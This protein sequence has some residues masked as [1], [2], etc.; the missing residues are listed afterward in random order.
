MCMRQLLAVALVL[1][2][3]AVSAGAQRGGGHGGGSAGFHGG[4]FSG[5][6]AV[7]SHG[8]YSGAGQARYAS[9]SRVQSYRTVGRGFAPGAGASAGH[10]MGSGVSS[11]RPA[12][13]NRGRDGRREGFRRGFP[14]VYPGLL[15]DGWV[16]PDYLDDGYPDDGGYY[17]DD[18]GDGSAGDPGVADN[19]VEQPPEQYEQPGQQYE[20]PGPEETPQNLYVAPRRPVAPALYEPDAVTLVFKD[21]RPSQQI[22]NYALTRTTLYV[23]DAHHRD[24]PVAD[25][26]LAA[27]EKVNREAG[28]NF[29]L[30]SAQ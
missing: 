18:P 8:G 11:A 28:V 25:L 9:G 15:N 13:Y 16:D 22:H 3:G 7:A 27:T 12:F 30:P 26:D 5:H 10:F 6:A 29:Q 21:G 19:Y 2:V 14:Y 24:I 23:T 1:S 4:G 20:Q 17:G